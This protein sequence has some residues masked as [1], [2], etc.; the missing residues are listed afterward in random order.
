MSEDQAK[1]LLGLALKVKA[2]GLPGNARAHGWG[3]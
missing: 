1:G 3:S 2:N